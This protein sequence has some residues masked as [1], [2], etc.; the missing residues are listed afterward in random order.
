MPKAIDVTGQ[1]FG[2]L[3]AKNATSKR[4]PHGEIYWLCACDCGASKEVIIGALRQG[5]VKSCGCIR[6]PDDLTGQKFSRLT[7]TAL[8]NER[9][10]DRGAKFEC[11]CTCGSR[12]TVS[13]KS[14]IQ[15][16][17]KSCG[18]WKREE[19]S[20]RLTELKTTHGMTGSTEYNIWANMI[21]RCTN[22][23][24][25]AYND[26]GGRGI[27]VCDRWKGS[28]EAFYA[29]MGPRPS[30][31]HTLDRRNTDGN[32]EPGNCRWVTWDVQQNNRRNNVRVDHEDASETLSNVARRSGVTYQSLWVRVRKKGMSVEEAI[33][34]IRNNQ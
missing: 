12:V 18:C 15:G 17:T 26:Y 13:R 10:A 9:D 32:Y 33:A 6:N 14:L 1:R 4:G 8:S 34:D 11:L 22:P 30:P 16:N 21:Q 25:Q 5:K 28:F 19:S 2:K 3:V 29:D 27:A 23:A 24:S 20:I 7:V 31:D